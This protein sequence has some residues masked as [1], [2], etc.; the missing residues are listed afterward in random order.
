MRKSAALL[1]FG[2][3][4]GF[5]SFETVAQT[6]PKQIGPSPTGQFQQRDGR[7]APALPEVQLDA[8]AYSRTGTR[9]LDIKP[10]IIG[11]EPAPIGA[12]PWQVSIGIS[13]LAPSVGHFCGGSAIAPNWVVTAAHC[14]DGSTQPDSI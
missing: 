5:L 12:Y 2:I 3:V 1:M 14:V 8:Q 6:I 11:G 10:F 13:S 9:I 7:S 4:A